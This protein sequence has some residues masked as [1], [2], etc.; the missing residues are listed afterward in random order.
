MV[1]PW[2]KTGKIILGDSA[3]ASLQTCDVM[4]ANGLKFIGPIKTAHK[5]FCHL[6]FA[7][8][9]LQGRGEYHGLYTIDKYGKIDKM[10]FMWLDRNRM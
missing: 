2:V 7:T 5:G 10:G 9:Q 1:C 6:A 4:K 8:Y 3:F